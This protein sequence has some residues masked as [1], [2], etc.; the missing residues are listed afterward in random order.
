[1]KQ[2]VILAGGKGT[3][4]REHLGDLPK[5]LIDVCGVPLLERQILLAKRYG[6][7]QALI[8][9]NYKADRIA[10]YCDSRGSWGID[11]QCIDD[12]EPRGTAGAVLNILDRLDDEF[13]VMYGDTMLH[14]DLDRFHRFHLQDPASSATLFLHPNDHPRDSD[15]VDLDESGRIAGFYP[16]PHDGDCYLPNLVNAALYWIRRS[17]LEPWRNQ[18][19]LLDFGKDIFSAMI[20]KGLILRGYSSPEYIKDVGTPA[21]IDKVRADYAAGRV[22]RAG[23]DHDQKAVF[24]DRDGTL[25]REVGHLCR[26]EQLELLP[27]VEDAVR[28]LNHAEYRVCVVTNQPVIARGECSVDG[29][30]QI[31]NKLETLLGRAGAYVDRIYYCPHH[32]ERGFAGEIAELK[33][34][35]D[36]RKPNT[37]LITSAVADLNISCAQSWLV[38]DSSADLLA[39]QRAGIRSILVETGRAG[40]DGKYPATPDF[41]VPDLSSAVD[42]IT[43]GY[44][45]LTQLLEPLARRVGPGALVFIGG[46]SRSGKSTMA[47][48]LRDVLRVKGQQCHALSTDRWLLNQE[49]R[50]KDVLARHDGKALQGLVRALAGRSTTVALTL[51]YYLRMSRKQ[52]PDSAV[53]RLEPSDVVIIEGVVALYLARLVES[54]HRIFVDVDEDTRKMRMMREYGL[55]GESAAAALIYG[56]R[57]AEEVPWVEATAKHAVRLRLPDFRTEQG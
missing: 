28:R 53:L 41:T 49:S 39:A 37:G 16:Y 19:G 40:L 29:M 23:L 5:P 44:A 48:A 26:P 15:L 42:L 11:V 17:A 13:L 57:F 3:R 54:S 47:S 2:V 7:T 50:G 27:G 31:H 35:C 32:P 24:L 36:C 6:F 10:G 51:P 4:L 34:E 38:G 9:V 46:Q 30:R 8:L 14:V 45:R 43:A 55:R 33:Q 52:I 25:N 56:D 12:G 22:E 1:M 18:P 20:A 21:R